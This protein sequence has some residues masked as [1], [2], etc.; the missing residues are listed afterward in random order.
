MPPP[1]SA[2]VQESALPPDTLPAALRPD[3]S[4]ARDDAHLIGLWLAGC[5]STH[6]QRAYARD[7]ASCLSGSGQPPLQGLTLADLQEWRAQ[8]QAQ[9]QAASSINRH[10]AAV[11]SLL[12]F[13]QRTGYL[14]FN[15]GA[16][17]RPLPQADRLAERI[18]SERDTL[19]LL[20]AA[21]APTPQ[22]RR[23]QALLQF[24]YYTGARVAEAC[25]LQWRDLQDLAGE[26]P[27]VAIHGKGGRTRHVALPLDCARAVAPL[28][29][30]P[31]D[32]ES[33]VFRT[34]SG[35]ALLP[36][37]AGQIV[38]RRRGAGRSHGTG[39]AA[40][41]APCPCQPRPGPRARPC[42]WYSTPWV[43]PRWP[44]PPAMCTC[45]RGKAVAT[46][47]PGWDREGGRRESL[48]Q[49]DVREA[50]RGPKCAAGPP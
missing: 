11:R 12:T 23:N 34:R 21:G 47:W 30:D 2:P 41:A 17:M 46:V 25:G 7:V 10:L 42:M 13:G 26:R 38:T 6:T 1:S 36:R 39:L 29:P 24:L 43:M 50:H 8:L 37:A 9:G 48:L 45:S 18:L 27:V 4:G 16:A 44:P 33:P 28:Q 35:R 15:V 5:S 32:P 49:I 3:R 40:L 14:Q 19:N 22:G 31:P 20:H